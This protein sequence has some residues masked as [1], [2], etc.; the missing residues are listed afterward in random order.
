MTFPQSF[1]A[2]AFDF[3]LRETFKSTDDSLVDTSGPGQKKAMIRALSRRYRK[4]GDDFLRDAIEVAFDW[5]FGIRISRNFCLQWIRLR[6][7]RSTIRARKGCWFS[8]REFRA[9]QRYLRFPKKS[10]RTLCIS[11]STIRL[12]R[13]R[14]RFT[15]IFGGLSRATICVGRM[16]V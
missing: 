15:A 1:P 11:T 7:G 2:K 13:L 9:F 3:G 8:L 4:E 16:A 14:S 10:I 6:P 12:F 5:L